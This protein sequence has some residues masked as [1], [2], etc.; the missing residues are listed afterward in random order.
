MSENFD[1]LVARFL[2]INHR[3][4]ADLIVI[5]SKTKESPKSVRSILWGA[6]TSVQNFMLLFF[7]QHWRPYSVCCYFAQ[8]LFKVST[9]RFS[10]HK[11]AGKVFPRSRWQETICICMD[12]LW[13]EYVCRDMKWEPST[14]FSQSIY[15]LTYVTCNFIPL[16]PDCVWIHNLS[17]WEALQLL[18]ED[19]KHCYSHTSLYNNGCKIKTNHMEWSLQK[20][21]PGQW[22]PCKSI[23]TL[24]E[25]S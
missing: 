8:F 2:C 12:M 13:V 7:D 17:E 14:N 6:W 5:C 4:S 19:L 25:N 23:P 21:S 18:M 1:L 3:L 20:Q 9:Q 16:F 15:P 10:Y 24:K 22:Q 11:P